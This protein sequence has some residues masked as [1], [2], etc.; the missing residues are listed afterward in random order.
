MSAVRFLAHPSRPQ[1]ALSQLILS[2][3]CACASVPPAPLDDADLAAGLEARDPRLVADLADLSGLAP[4]ALAR[5]TPEELA[6]PSSAGFWRGCA[7]AWNPSVRAARR[8]LSAVLASVG[9]A[10]APEAIELGVENEDFDTLGDETKI[11]LSFDLLGILGLGPSHAARVSAQARV[12]RAR[13]SFERALWSAN[14]EVERARVRLAASRARLDLLGELL[15]Q[16][17]LQDVRLEILERRG[18]LS[19]VDVQE[20]Q[21][22]VHELEHAI[23]LERAGLAGLRAE[24]AQQCGLLPRHPALSIPG[25]EVL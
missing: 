6:D 9:A 7:F 3:L 12:Q 5:P 19:E 23:S 18:R 16:V 11:A 1:F 13:S 10:G 8:E 20:A 24:L 21:L 4:L 22:V 15:V 14:F 17:Q 25:P 2:V